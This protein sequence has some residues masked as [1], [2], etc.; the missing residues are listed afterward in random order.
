M[1]IYNCAEYETRIL[2][3]DELADDERRVVDAHLAT[4]DGCRSFLSALMEVDLTL[5]REVRALASRPPARPSV[6]PLLLD[7]AGW[8]SLIAALLAVTIVVAPAEFQ[9]TATWLALG[10]AVVVGSAY[11]GFTSWREIDG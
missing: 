9:E 5:S 2:E 11:F 6:W 4:C 1:P 10:G 8:A 3:Y 7:F